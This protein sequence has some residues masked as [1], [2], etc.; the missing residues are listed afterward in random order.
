MPQGA[1]PTPWEGLVPLIAV[2]AL[3]HEPDYGEDDR[4]IEGA[5]DVLLDRLH[6]DPPSVDK[7]ELYKK[8]GVVDFL[9]TSADNLAKTLRGGRVRSG[10]HPGAVSDLDHWVAWYLVSPRAE[11]GHSDEQILAWMERKHPSL[12][13]LYAVRDVARLRELSLPPPDRKPPE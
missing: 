1:R 2:H 8:R 12:A 13:E 7:A 3:L 9:K 4:S 10:H 5:V 11:K 6:P